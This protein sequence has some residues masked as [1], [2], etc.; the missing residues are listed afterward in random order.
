MYDQI[1]HYYDL[2]HADLTEDIDF[3]LD[4]ARQSNG[5][6]L[7]LGC[8]S[9]RLLLPLARAEFT[10]TGV[11]NSMAMLARA[12]AALQQEPQAV[13]NRVTLLQ[14]DM[15]QMELDNGRFAL[16]IIPYN[17]F[18]HLDSAQKTAA[19]KR[20]R[21]LMRGN[22]RSGNGRLFIDL[23]NPFAIAD[24]PDDQD[25]VL[26]NSFTDPQTGQFIQQLAR[27]HLNEATQCLQITWVYDVSPTGEP[28]P[29][30]NPVQRTT[31]QTDYHYLFPHQIDLL[32]QETGFR[33]TDLSGDYDGS[34]FDEESERLLITAVSIS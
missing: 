12:R 8:G 31:V 29:G 10:V 18:M 2:T 25:L 14:A 5:P 26:E 22:G 4:L 6:I 32:L 21:R 34:I 9:G 24:T 3:I 17:T 13:Q 16:T 33:L 23:I 7:E 11:D 28:L 15:A 1:A 30:D 27:N 20:V 19:L